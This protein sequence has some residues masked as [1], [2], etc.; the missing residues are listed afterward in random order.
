MYV[1][2]IFQILGKPTD[3]RGILGI[4]AGG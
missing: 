1:E 2:E 4:V 3:E